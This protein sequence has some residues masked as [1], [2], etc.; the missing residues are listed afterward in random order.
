MY[1]IKTFVLSLLLLHALCMRAQESLNFEKILE[2]AWALKDRAEPDSALQLAQALL[3]RIQK[4]Q[5]RVM[6]GNCYNL[7]GLVYRDL[8]DFPQ[9]YTSLKQ[10]LDI[11]RELD[12]QKGIA[13]VYN[14]VASVKIKERRYVE[15]SDTVGQS[16]LIYRHLRDSVHLA[17]AFVTLS[18]VYQEYRDYET[19]AVWLRQAIETYRQYRDSAGLADAEYNFGNL[20]YQLDKYDSAL[21]HYY[22]ALALYQAMGDVLN[23]G[24]AHNMLA[25]TYLAQG[26]PDS[27]WHAQLKA[28]ALFQTYEYPEGMFKVYHGKGLYFQ[29]QKQYKKAIEQFKLAQ[30]SGKG[31]ANMKLLPLESMAEVYR[32]LGMVDSALYYEKMA[33]DASQ[34]LFRNDQDSSIIEQFM[35]KWQDKKAIQQD[36]MTQSKNNR[37]LFYCIVLLLGVLLGLIFWAAARHRANKRERARQLQTIKELTNNLEL[38]YI[39]ARFEG[40]QTEKKA[41]GRELHDRIGAMMATLK[42]RYEAIGEKL[43]AEPELQQLMRD[44]NHTFGAI[45]HDLR[46]ISHQLESEGSAEKVELV[47]ALQGLCKE[48]SNSGNINAAFFVHGLDGRLDYKTEINLLHILQEIIANTLKHSEAKNLTIQLTKLEQHL[49]LMVEDDGIGFEPSLHRDGVGLRHIEERVAALSGTVQIDSKKNAGVTT[50]I[51]IPL[52]SPLNNLTVP[53][54]H[55]KTN[56]GL[57]GG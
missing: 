7:L 53:S 57:F 44:A 32:S 50:I 10:A 43:A 3:P 28:E 47:T 34:I 18:N 1:H 22:K 9:A 40:Q 11:R 38:N 19:A 4:D 23:E 12:D 37:R 5:D 26:K 13:S 6:E 41:L 36:L 25:A 15:A 30:N 21:S 33:I 8:N 54:G 29:Y 2:Q 48:I 49:T 31:T 20:Y 56:P 17:K 39:N 52:S 24:L 42:W 51:E 16:I 27:S 46:A 14:N 55:D 35:Q 45:Y